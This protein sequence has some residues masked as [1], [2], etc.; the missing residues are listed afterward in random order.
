[1]PLISWNEV[2]TRAV[3]FAARWQGETHERSRSGY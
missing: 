1:M 3:Q 2:E